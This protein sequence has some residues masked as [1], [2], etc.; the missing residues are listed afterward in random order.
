MPVW[1]VSISIW[2][3]DGTR[4]RDDPRT[5]ERTAVQLL[6]G[7]GNDLEWWA[8]PPRLIGH[9]RVGLTAQEN[10]TVDACVLGPVIADAGESGPLRPRTPA[11]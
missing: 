5:A 7:V 10:S 11:P 1:H 2:T 8:W 9:L 6:A 3:P 4:R